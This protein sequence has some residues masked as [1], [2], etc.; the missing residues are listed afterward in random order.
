VNPASDKARFLR[1]LAFEIRRKR[2]AVEALADCIDKEGRGGRHRVFR[3]ASAMLETEG[4]L[5][6]LQAAG[7]IGEEAA[8]I[9]AEV[10]AANDHRL[11]AGAINNLAD[12]YGQQPDP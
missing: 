2:P 4:F 12:Y 10:V 1:A 6:A 5:P 7:L 11:L 9:L 3:Q 8:A